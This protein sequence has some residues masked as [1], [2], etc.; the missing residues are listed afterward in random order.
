M[1]A[2]KSKSSKPPVSTIVFESLSP[3][4][5]VYKSPL[6]ELN[7]YMLLEELKLIVPYISSTART[8]SAIGVMG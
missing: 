5:D 3:E 8:S 2:D 7:S 4:K 1:Y 6:D